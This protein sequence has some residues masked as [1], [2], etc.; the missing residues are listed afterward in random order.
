MESLQLKKT[1]NVGKPGGLFGGGAAQG[2]QG[3]GLFGGGGAAGATGA[4]GGGLFG[5]P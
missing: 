5:Q 1:T 4:A 3:G 2:G